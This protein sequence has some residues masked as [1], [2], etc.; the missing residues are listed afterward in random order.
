MKSLFYITIISTV[1]TISCFAQSDYCLSF[2][3]VDDHVYIGDVNDLG[4]SD[5]TLEGWVN[6]ND[7]A[8]TGQVI[9]GKGITSVGT[10]PG[11]GYI[12][13][14]NEANSGDFDFL[15]I[16]SDAT[17]TQISGS[18]LVINTWHHLAAVRSGI[19][20]YLYLDGVLVASDSTA[21]VYNVNTDMPLAIGVLHKGGLA[22]NASHMNGKI[23]EVRIW[24]VA[25]TQTEINDFKNCAITMPEAGL[26][27]V[28]N[29]NEGTGLAAGDS[30]GY[31]NHGTLENGPLWTTS[32]VANQCFSKIDDN[33]SSTKVIIYPNP[34][35]EIFSTTGIDELSNY[36]ISDI[37]GKVVLKG[38]LDDFHPVNISRLSSGTYVINIKLGSENIV[39]RIVVE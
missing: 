18:G 26:V 27:A 29:F 6:Y 31:S 7:P 4:S 36:K 2:D 11:A 32:T 34:I 14:T 28:Y 35:K 1:S 5:F 33:S 19:Y 16:N 24:S 9:L 23:D 30:S 38:K 20:M 8:G 17:S 3:G 15:I 39:E 10:P 13:T 21:T 37:S 12:L 22:S 25:R